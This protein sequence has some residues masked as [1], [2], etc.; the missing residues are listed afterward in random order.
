MNFYT[1]VIA[2][3]SK[4]SKGKIHPCYQQK[5]NL[6]FKLS[7]DKDGSTSSY[8]I[9]IFIDNSAF[10]IVIVVI[11]ESIEK[12]FDTHS[13]YTHIFV[14]THAHAKVA[15]EIGFEFFIPAVICVKVI[16]LIIN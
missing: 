9:A 6:V 14:D 12:V 11:V 13:N 2:S 15:D 8:D 10:V 7:L 3:T 1:L 5:G 4:E 16:R